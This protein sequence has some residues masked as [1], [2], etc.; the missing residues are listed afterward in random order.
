MKGHLCEYGE[1]VG[2]FRRQLQNV[3]AE[4]PEGSDQG[5]VLPPGCLKVDWSPV[6]LKVARHKFLLHDHFIC[7]LN[8]CQGIGSSCNTAVEG[9]PRNREVVG[10]NSARCC[11]FFLFSILSVV[12]P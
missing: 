1:C 5:C 7:P 6:Q 4:V 11:A 10:S 8:I 12:S 9:T 3:D 2:L